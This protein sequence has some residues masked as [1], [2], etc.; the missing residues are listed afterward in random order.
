MEPR[1]LNLREELEDLEE[2]IL[3]PWAARARRSRGRL[4]PEPECPLR[5][6]FQRD[7][8]RI[9]HSKAF[10]RLK[11]K[12]QVFLAPTGDHYRTRLTHTLEVAQIARTIARALRLNEDLTEAIALGHDLGHTPFGHA[13]E[14]VLNELVP[15]GFR[16]YEQSL[17]VVDCLEKE[18]RGLNLTH[19]VRDGIV[20]HSKGLGPIFAPEKDPPLTLEAEVVRLADLI[21]YVNHDLDDALRAGIIRERDIPE[22]ALRVL[23]R[24]HAA[25]INTLVTDLVRET[26]SAGDGR[27]HLSDRVLKALSDLRAFL[28]ERVYRAREVRRE[29]EKARKILIEL[30]EY[31]LNRDS[32][33][34]REMPCYTEEVPKERMVCDFIA[35][36]TDRYALYLYEK[37]FLP[38]P[39]PV[40]PSPSE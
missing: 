12:T 18:G 6:C 33:W 15:G 22:S 5:T 30:Y 21:A 14:E 2:K 7:R 16:H 39:Y 27:L 40:V 24:R 34:G 17:R 1:D 31:Y 8:D 9:I 37:L 26:L 32:V 35:G 4:K 11:H 3:S 28:F 10:R 38:R 25:R 23:G 36:M 13:G 20:K 19:E 29:F